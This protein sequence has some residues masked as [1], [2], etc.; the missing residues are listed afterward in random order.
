[1]KLNLSKDQWEKI[2]Q[3]AGW[4]G[5]VEEVSPT[6]FINFMVDLSG[7]NDPKG[8]AL[9]LRDLCVKFNVKMD[10]VNKTIDV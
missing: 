3:S 9:A 1:M 5:D 8:F 2:G 6:K 7:S 4:D 10:V